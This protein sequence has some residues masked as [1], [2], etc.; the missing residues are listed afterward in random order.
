M[1]DA[2][3]PFNSTYTMLPLAHSHANRSEAFNDDILFLNLFFSLEF[4]LS[5]FRSL[6]RNRMHK[7]FN[8]IGINFTRRRH[9]TNTIACAKF[10][11][12]ESNPV[13]FNRSRHSC[14]RK[15]C[16]FFFCLFFQI[17]FTI[18][19]CA[20]WKKRFKLEYDN[21]ERKK[22]SGWLS[23]PIS[24]RGKNDFL[25]EQ[26]SCGDGATATNKISII[27][28]LSSMRRYGVFHSPSFSLDACS[29]YSRPCV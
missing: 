2:H 17:K 26:T 20:A 19:M 29:S 3:L 6:K 5:I 25:S 11:Q 10:S 15:Y 13:S 27:I 14:E 22:K 18:F 1:G 12:L 8:F 23:H 21:F 28:S 4:T 16:F 9:L 24:E 7:Q